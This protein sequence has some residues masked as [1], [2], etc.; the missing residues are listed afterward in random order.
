MA[1]QTNFVIAAQSRDFTVPQHRR[2][3]VVWP[4]GVHD[5]VIKEHI[6]DFTLA[7]H[8]RTFVVYP[9]AD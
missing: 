9:G 3:F 4:D 6:R 5:F 1:L 7:S 8:A 2:V